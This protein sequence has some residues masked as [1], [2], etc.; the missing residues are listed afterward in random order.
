MEFDDDF[1]Y[2]FDDDF[3][4]KGAKGIEGKKKYFSFS[5][6]YKSYK[7]TK[8]GDVFCLFLNVN[9]DLEWLKSDI[10]NKNIFVNP[11]Q[12]Y[13]ELNNINKI[14]IAPKGF[15]FLTE[16]TNKLTNIEV[17]EPFQNIKNKI[18]LKKEFEKYEFNSNDI[19]IDDIITFG[20]T[21]NRMRN[22]TNINNFIVLIKN[23]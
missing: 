19:L 8:A 21:L 9:T 16:I 18:T 12:T 15:H 5:N 10:N 22:L 11:L 7:S 13:L 3:E 17:I 14:I 6:G 20:S 23:F 1:E 4:K 2:E